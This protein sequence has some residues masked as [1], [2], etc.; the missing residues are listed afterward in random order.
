MSQLPSAF[1]NFTGS[2]AVISGRS[3][4]CFRFFHIH[5]KVAKNTATKEQ[6]NTR[7]LTRHLHQFAAHVCSKHTEVPLRVWPKELVIADLLKALA[8]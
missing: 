1:H 3:Y 8:C 6:T 4:L 7:K 5:C 2:F